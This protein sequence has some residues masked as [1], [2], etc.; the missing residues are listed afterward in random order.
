VPPSD[1]W[2]RRLRDGDVEFAAPAAHPAEP[3]H[4]GT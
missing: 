2:M 1:F 4:E 3:A